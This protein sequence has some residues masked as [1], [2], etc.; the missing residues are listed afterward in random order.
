MPR[1][2]YRA[3]APSKVENVSATDKARATT[4]KPAAPQN[5]S[6]AKNSSARS[7]AE[8]EE[9]AKRRWQD[10]SISLEKASQSQIT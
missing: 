10:E 7:S 8:I 1:W 5:T 3:V 9:E 2:P 4:P 6:F